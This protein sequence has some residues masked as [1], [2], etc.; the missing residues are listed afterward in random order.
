MEKTNSR[1]FFLFI[2][3]SLISMF[4][5][6]QKGYADTNW[7]KYFRKDALLNTYM[8]TYAVMDDNLWVGT[9]GD[10]LVVNDGK[11][12]T[13]FT[14]KNTRSSP[15]QNDGLISDYITC[16]SIDEKKGRIWLGTN[17]GLS[18]CDLEGKEWKSFKAKDGL[19]NDVIRDLALD[20]NGHLWVG[21]PSGVAQ[22]DGEDWK[23]HNEKTGLQACSV[24]S[25]K[26]KGESIWLG[27]VGGTVSRYKDGEWKT[28]MSY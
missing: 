14:N 20:K 27:T 12:K 1:W 26:A 2:L 18:S 9:Y 13:S 25:L 19:P 8:R 5:F 3:I 11:K 23:I 7:M 15:A 28:F 6:P 21:T 22:Y 4:F 16:M 24:H 17:E 10:G